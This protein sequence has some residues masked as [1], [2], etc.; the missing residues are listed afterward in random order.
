MLVAEDGRCRVRLLRVVTAVLTAVGV[1]VICVAG[2]ASSQTT[3]TVV[4]SVPVGA[5]PMTPLLDEGAARVFVPNAVDATVT[6]VDT[7]ARAVVGTVAVSSVEGVEIRSAAVDPGR[8]RLFVLTDSNDLVVIDTR[9]SDILRRSAV[10]DEAQDVTVD[11]ARGRVYVL[12]S[13]PSRLT[14]LSAG[15][16]SIVGSTKAPVSDIVSPN[17]RSGR[18]FMDDRSAAGGIVVVDPRTGSVVWSLRGVEHAAG[19]VFNA[20]GRRAYIPLDD[21][22]TTGT[23]VVVDTRARRV[24][25]RVPAGPSPRGPALDPVHRE[26]YATSA[27]GTVTV[28][29]TVTNQ[30]RAELPLSTGMSAPTIDSTGA[31]LYITNSGTRTLSIVA[32]S[33]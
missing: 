31:F 28:F 13:S 11:P 30:Q 7:V 5:G 12:S 18:L 19:F 32:V 29:D 6:V 10:P 8:H 17:P 26:G 25:A 33:P 1:S 4:A 9:T 24:L 15:S 21:G 20:S 22:E 27:N 2:S 14:A 16:G 23:I 3:L